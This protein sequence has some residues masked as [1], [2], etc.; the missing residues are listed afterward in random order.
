MAI[1][2]RGHVLNAT[3]MDA[4]KGLIKKNAAK[5]MAKTLF[6]R[7]AESIMLDAGCPLPMAAVRAS[8]KSFNVEF[9]GGPWDGKVGTMKTQP[10]GDPLSLPIHVGDHVGRYNMNTG[11]WVPAE[12]QQ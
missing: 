10:D 12:N 2:I 7:T 11:A 9:I 4:I 6:E 1:S 8:P 5:L 3:Q